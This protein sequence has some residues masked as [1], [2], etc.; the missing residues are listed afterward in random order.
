M[1]AAPRANA[2]AA[3]CRRPPAGQYCPGDGQA[4]NCANGKVPT[5]DQTDC[6][7][8]DSGYVPNST[9]DACVI[10]CGPGW[11]P[12]AAGNGC[13]VVCNAGFIPTPDNQSC[14]AAPPP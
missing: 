14:V 10:S 2:S 6:Q 1:E 13:N 9:G 8:C 7:A 3:E 12:N 4:F 11:T 5:S